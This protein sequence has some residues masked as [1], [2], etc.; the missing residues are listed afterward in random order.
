M[1]MGYRDMN[2][3]CYYA[4]LQWNEELENSGTRHSIHIHTSAE[5]KD[6]EKQAPYQIILE[7]KSFSKTGLCFVAFRFAAEMAYLID[8]AQFVS[9]TKFHHI[10]DNRIIATGIV[11]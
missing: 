5:Q 6:I 7:I 4:T 1:E 9:G 10:E 8:D 2:T 11:I 3:N